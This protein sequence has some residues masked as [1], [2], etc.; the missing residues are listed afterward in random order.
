MVRKS[1]MGLKSF[2]FDE[3]LVG[4]VKRNS[5]FNSRKYVKFQRK[6]LI[7]NPILIFNF[8]KKSLAR[9]DLICGVRD[10]D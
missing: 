10:D 9:F 6:L 7:L 3:V 8:A 4:M 1:Q 5:F 2:L